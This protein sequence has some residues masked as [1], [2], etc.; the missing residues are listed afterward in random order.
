MHFLK[1]V[2]LWKKHA[3]VTV[4]CACGSAR[5]DDAVL[6]DCAPDL[7]PL[8]QARHGYDEDHQSCALRCNPFDSFET[9]ELHE[10]KCVQMNSFDPSTK[11]RCAGGGAPLKLEG[12][13]HR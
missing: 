4:E 3:R 7:S 5:W 8:R 11:K 1:T 10:S 12:A 2:F 9:R 6:V 13:R